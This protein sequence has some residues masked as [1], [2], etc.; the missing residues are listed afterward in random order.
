MVVL[1][2]MPIYKLTVEKKW[3]EIVLYLSLGIL[4][5]TPFLIRNVMISGY[6]LYPYPEIDLFSVDWKMPASNLIRDRDEIKAWAWGLRDV[7][8]ANA[9][10]SE[11]FPVWK[12]NIGRNMYI[13]FLASVICIP[14]ALAIGVIHGLRKKEWNFLHISICMIMCF[15]FWFLFAPLLRYG[16]VYLLLLPF[17]LLGNVLTK[18]EKEDIVI[19]VMVALGSYYIAPM[20]KSSINTE[21]IYPVVSADYELKDCYTVD[22]ENLQLRIPQTGDQVG[23]YDFPSTPYEY[24]LGMIELRGKTF[25]EGF[26][27]VAQQ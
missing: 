18:V 1:T 9:P 24:V 22:F 15:I 2:I 4:V 25:S 13:V 10:F 27:P 16:Q 12:S 6:L 23:Y 21:E 26:K 7:N 19:V 5:I 20:I 14:L 11:W 17:Y 3:G 8:R